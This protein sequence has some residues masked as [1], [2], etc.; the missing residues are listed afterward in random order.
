MLEK[1]VFENGRQHKI[2]VKTAKNVFCTE[3]TVDYGE[4]TDNIYYCVIL[5]AP[6]KNLWVRCKGYDCRSCNLLLFS[7]LKKIREATQ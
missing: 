5:S 2:F 1:T 6:E 4:Y 3:K 7:A